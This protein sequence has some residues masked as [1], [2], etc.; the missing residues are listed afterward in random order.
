MPPDTKL[1]S[2]VTSPKTRPPRFTAFRSVRARMFF[3]VLAVTIPIYS[4]ALY[5]SYDAGAHR[6][7]TSAERDADDLAARLA[8]EVDAVIRPIEGGIRTVAYQIEHV[9]PPRSQYAQRILGILGAWPNVYGSTIA[10][11]VGEGSS[12]KPFAPY[13]SRR[14]PGPGAVAYSDLAASSYG[15][16]ELDWYRRAA[17]GRRPVWSAPYFDAGGGETWMVTYSVP[18]FRKR[19]NGERAFAGVITADLALDWMRKAAADA[20]LGP[21]GMGWLSSPPGDRSFV[22]PIGATANRIAAFDPGMDQDA[23]RRAGEGMLSRRVTFALLPPGI[24]SRPAYLA[25]RH[26]ETLQWRLMLV[27]P[28]SELLAEAR[29][30]LKRQLWLGVMGLLLLTPAIALVATSIARPLRALAESVSLASTGGALN[31]TLPSASGRDEVGVLTG[32][33]RRL[34]DS[35]QEHIRLRAES[36][37]A[38]ARLE[39]EL[40]IAASIQQ[41]M[42]PHGGAVALPAGVQVAAS[43]VP[44]KQVGGDLYD[45]FT[46]KDNNLLFAVGDVSDK[47]IPAALFM[48]RLSALL[49][50]LGASGELPDRLLTTINSRLSEGNDACMFVTLGCGVLDVESGEVRYAS[51]GHEAPLRLELEGTVSTL[52][53]ESD[54]AIGIETSV[55]YALRESRMAPGDTL[56]LFTDGVTEAQDEK[57]GLWGAERLADLLRAAPDDHP[58]ALVQEIVA[59]LASPTSGYEVTDDLTVMAIRFAPRWARTRRGEEGAHWEFDVTPSSEGLWIQRRRLRD[60][61]ESRRISPERMNDVELIVEELLTNVVRANAPD[62]S[63]ILGLALLPAHIRLVVRD[64]G[65]EYNPLDRRSPDLDADIMDR[66][67]GGLGVHLV[68]ELSEECSYARLEGWNVFVARLRRTPDP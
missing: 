33:L 46:V 15:Y 22:A 9:D 36:L 52:G 56:V 66:E 67:T 31:F 3:W 55:E 44:A 7:E 59:T 45:Y 4:G 28:R 6:L 20:A 5:I 58:A 43:L 53:E 50:V 27:I 18:F 51:A 2:N 25:V 61:L 62:I 35:L 39:Q 47:G 65:L 12:E 60:I 34:R 26:L 29:G 63:M 32:A 49:R 48:A 42:L 41:S 64:N 10:A 54:A 30:L 57:G 1:R 8:S 11:E 38:Q 23:V 14:G 16:G 37:A 24:S 68:R 21:L 13:Y 40:E 17:D 19:P